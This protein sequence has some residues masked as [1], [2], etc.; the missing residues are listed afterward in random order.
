MQYMQNKINKYLGYII[1]Q[2][3]IIYPPPQ[4]KKKKIKKKKKQKKIKI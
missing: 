4:K 1:L 3:N 2:I